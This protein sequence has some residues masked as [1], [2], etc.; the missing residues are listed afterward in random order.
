M[1]DETK[2]RQEMRNEFSAETGDDVLALDWTRDAASR[3]SREWLL[4]VMDGQH[5]VLCSGF[6]TACEPK[7]V[8]GILERLCK[9]GVESKAL[10]G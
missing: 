8:E 1:A 5:V 6:T 4:H 7:G 2:R 3:R 10:R 9:Q